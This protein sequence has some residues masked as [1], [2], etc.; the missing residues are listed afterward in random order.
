[1]RFSGLWTPGSDRLCVSEEVEKSK[2]FLVETE[3]L[4]RVSVS[5]PLG[6]CWIVLFDFT[7]PWKFMVLAPFIYDVAVLGQAVD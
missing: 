6:A 4:E 2:C 7:S 3:Q 5:Q 1:M